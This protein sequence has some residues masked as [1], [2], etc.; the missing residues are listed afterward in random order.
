MKQLIPAALLGCLLAPAQALAQLNDWEPVELCASAEDSK[1]VR[2]YY[3]DSVG[4]PMPIPSRRLKLPEVQVTTALPREKSI[5]TRTTPED[6]KKIWSSIDEWGEDT[7]VRLVFTLGGQH[8][9]DFPSLVPVRQEDLDDGWLDVYADDGQGVHGHLWLDPIRSV[10]A[11]DIPARDNHR[12]RTI[13]FYSADG[14]L[15]I[16]VYASLS[17][18]EFDPAAAEGFKRTWDLI[19]SMPRA[20][21]QGAASKK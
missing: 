12:T 3:E 7:R 21:A 13:N 16:G 17:H 15:V 1:R 14:N 8:I 4:A 10:H 9:H 11:V 6:V 2:D 20:C 5:G 18:R 19:A